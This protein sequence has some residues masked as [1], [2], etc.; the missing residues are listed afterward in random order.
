MSNGIRSTAQQLL[1]QNHS[2]RGSNR[3]RDAVGGGGGVGRFT[4]NKDS[5]DDDM[6]VPFLEHRSSRLP[7]PLSLI[8]SRDSPRLMK[9]HL[10]AEFF[11]SNLWYGRPKVVILLRDPRDCLAAQFEWYK[12][13]PYFAFS[14]DWDDFFQLFRARMLHEADWFDHTELWWSFRNQPNVLVLKF[15][16]LHNDPRPSVKRLA[17]FCNRTISVRTSSRR[18]YHRT[19]DYHN[20]NGS[21]NGKSDLDHSSSSGNGDGPSDDNDTHLKMPSVKSQ[22]SHRPS[23][24]CML[25]SS[26]ED[27]DTICDFIKESI[28]EDKFTGMWKQYFSAAQSEY[29]AH[30]FRCYFYGT[31]LTFR[32]SHHSPGSRGAGCHS[33]KPRR[34]VTHTTKPR[35]VCTLPHP[36]N[37]R[38]ITPEI[39]R[40]H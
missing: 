39:Q 26:S 17:D 30:L 4:S 19:A 18:N 22:S 12:S 40:C 21:S 8:S 1:Q 7:D 16:E 3:W 28:A 24:K 29:I 11:A 14:G 32:Y 37:N 2:I 31:G 36:K 13:N 5:E 27:C 35:K 9:T 33:P 38:L 23:P 10:S 25:S 34:T 6:R 20:S 15:E